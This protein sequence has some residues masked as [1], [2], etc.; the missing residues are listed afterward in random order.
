[1]SVQS[2]ATVPHARPAVSTGNALLRFALKLDAV[3][4]GANGVAYL[5]AA[6]LLDGPLGVPDGF[7]RGIGAFLVAYA[8]VVWLLA[9]RPSIPRAGV[10][11]VI[12]AN[13]TWAIGSVVM[14]ALDWHSPTVGGGVW[15]ALQALVVAG[16]AALQY[17]A[18]RR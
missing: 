7:L 11:A 13:A 4:T 1:M 10:E 14:L 3:V 12:A 18:A 8:A 9:T 16:F 2:S 17:V 5:A 15:I 6:G